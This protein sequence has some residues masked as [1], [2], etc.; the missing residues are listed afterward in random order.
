LANLAQR[1]EIGGKKIFVFS[2]L[3]PKKG[4]AS[5]VGRKFGFSAQQKHLTTLIK[6]RGGRGRAKNSSFFKKFVRCTINKDRFFA[7]AMTQALSKAK[8]TTHHRIKFLLMSLQSRFALRLT[9][10]TNLAIAIFFVE[11]EQK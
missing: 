10:A 4:K 5:S 9:T 3:S 1:K 11:D 8:G 6:G 7:R 2:F